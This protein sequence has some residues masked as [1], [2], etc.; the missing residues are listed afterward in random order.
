MISSTNYKRISDLRLKHG[1]IVK[2]TAQGQCMEPLLKEGDILT[3][4]KQTFYAIGDIV[5][6]CHG[7]RVI[8]HRVLEFSEGLY[9]IKGDNSFASEHVDYD[10]IIGK[11]VEVQ[12]D[13]VS[14]LF[15]LPSDLTKEIVSLSLEVNRI[16]VNSGC[17]YEIAQSA[18]AYAKIRNILKRKI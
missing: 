10:E 7:N 8:A 15:D 16:F 5:I 6:A 11:V 9:H 2:V 18:D 14:V 13:G 4:K 12:R 3:V 17:S 1:Y